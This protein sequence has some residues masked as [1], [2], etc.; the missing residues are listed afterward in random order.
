M[1]TLKPEPQSPGSGSTG[2]RVITAQQQHN[3]PWMSGGGTEAA[4]RVYQRERKALSADP[5]LKYIE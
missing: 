3:W 1:P 4:Q 2:Q 5:N